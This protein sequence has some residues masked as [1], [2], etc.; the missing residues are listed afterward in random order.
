[1]WPEKQAK[2]LIAGLMAP[3]SRW[4]DAD[5]KYRY[6]VHDWADHAEDGV[7]KKL[8]RKG[9]TF[10]IPSGNSPPLSGFCPDIVETA[11]RQSPD[12]V[13]TAERQSPDNVETKFTPRARAGPLPLPLPLP[14]PCH[15]LP[16]SAG[17]DAEWWSERWYSRHPKKKHKVLVE[18]CVLKLAQRPGAAHLA[19]ALFAEIDAA[20]MALCETEDWRKEHGR[21]APRLDEWLEDEGWKQYR[22]AHDTGWSD[23]PV[24]HSPARPME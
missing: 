11:E 20:H 3:D 1:M 10:A 13:E 2:R 19:Q 21:F 24:Y 23:L 16:A 5:Q 8:A 17:V 22:P 4:L 15:C 12:I 18:Q 9:S 14:L 7:R 6:L